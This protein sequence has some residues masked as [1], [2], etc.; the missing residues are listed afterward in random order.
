MGKP[1]ETYDPLHAALVAASCSHHRSAV[2]RAWV[3]ARDDARLAYQAWS[4]APRN[5]KRDAYVA[6]RAAADRE[7]VAAHCF[8]TADRSG[9][10]VT[11]ASDSR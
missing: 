2:Y 7:D 1:A 5:G 6:Y 11:P 10:A 9:G 3:R 4:S 8:L